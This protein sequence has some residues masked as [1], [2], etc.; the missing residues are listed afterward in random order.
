MGWFSD[1]F[2]SSV[3]GVVDSVGNAIDSLVTSD[4]ERMNLKNELVKIKAT[5]A[6]QSKELENKYEEEIS[7]RWVSDNSGNFLTK[8]IRPLVLAYLTVAITLLAITDGN[9]VFNDY[10]FNIGPEWVDLI[11]VSYVTAIAAFFGGKSV[12]RVKNKIVER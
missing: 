1:I 3:S 4:E 12:E 9:I 7:K 6:L 2:S 11:K 5:A 10:T 8:S